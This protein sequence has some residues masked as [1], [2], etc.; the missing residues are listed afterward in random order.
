MILARTPREQERWYALW[1]LAPG[2]IAADTA[3]DLERDPPTML[4]PGLQCR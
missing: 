3:E 1:L 2:W 4:Q